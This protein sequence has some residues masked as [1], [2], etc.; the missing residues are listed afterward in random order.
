M[1][2]SPS[3]R[4]SFRGGVE[5]TFVAVVLVLDHPLAFY[6]CGFHHTLVVKY[7]VVPWT[8]QFRGQRARSV[9]NLSKKIF[10]YSVSKLS[11]KT[12]CYSVSGVSTQLR[13]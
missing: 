3:Y 5:I 13:N 10:F 12:I 2:R 4:Q 7:D 1:S 9:V 8:D 11:K 6:R